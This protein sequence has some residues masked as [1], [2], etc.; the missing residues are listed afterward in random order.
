MPATIYTINNILNYDFGSTAYTPP[1]TF[2]FGLSLSILTA[3]VNHEFVPTAM[4]YDGSKHVT[5]TFDNDLITYA[6]MMPNDTVTI[7][8]VDAAF[9]T[10][11][12]DGEWLIYGSTP[13]SITFTTSI[14]PTGT[15]PQTLTGGLV[16]WAK[17][18]EPNWIGNYGRT[19]YTNNK[20]TWGTS[21]YGLL[22]NNIPIVFPE[23]DLTW[24]TLKSIFI[25]TND[26]IFGGRVLWFDELE[27]HIPMPEGN[28]TLTFE[29]D[30]VHISI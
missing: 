8:G 20:T 2:Y 23:S 15:T 1:A 25:A 9:S 4:S 27:P 18:D 21:L 17:T 5:L 24:G 28:T 19:G 14:Q 7:E 29:A 6:M 12:I 22:S 10:T 13:T 30:T 26:T 11:N 3:D 16:T